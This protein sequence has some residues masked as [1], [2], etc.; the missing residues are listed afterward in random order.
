MILVNPFP[1]ESPDSIR[2]QT[3]EHRFNSPYVR[4]TERTISKALRARST[5]EVFLLDSA[6]TVVYR[7][8][9]DDQYGPDYSRPEAGRHFLRDALN[10][11]GRPIYF[12]VTQAEA[13]PDGHPRMHCYG[14]AAFSTLF[15]TTPN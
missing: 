15:W 1:S 3:G 6:R 7:G 13:F 5:T 11:T 14:D 9:L 12:S 10:A 4:D 2:E 8:A